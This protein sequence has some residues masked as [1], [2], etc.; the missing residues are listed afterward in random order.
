[1]TVRFMVL[2][3]LAIFTWLFVLENI[4]VANEFARIGYREGK[5]KAYEKIYKQTLKNKL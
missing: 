5:R 1:M 2:V 3:G 4:W